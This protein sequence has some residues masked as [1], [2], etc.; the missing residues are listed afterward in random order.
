[1]QNNVTYS[2]SVSPVI[3]VFRGFGMIFAERERE[4]E[5][6]REY[7][8]VFAGARNLKKLFYNLY[9]AGAIF[10]AGRFKF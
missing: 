9:L 1:M 2:S 8:I 3:R 7:T 5:R 10:S 6:E 4:R